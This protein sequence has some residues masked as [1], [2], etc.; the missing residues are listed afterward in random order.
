MPTNPSKNLPSKFS[1]NPFLLKYLNFVWFPVIIM[2]ID[3]SVM[4]ELDFC[5]AFIQEFRNWESASAWALEALYMVAYEIRV[6]AE[7]VCYPSF[8]CPFFFFF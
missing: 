7:S 4:L 3:Y 1:P 5:S 2:I 8:C 6:L